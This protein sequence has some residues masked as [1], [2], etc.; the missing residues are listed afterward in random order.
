M[1]INAPLEL[2]SKLSRFGKSDITGTG[3]INNISLS[4]DVV[5]FT[6]NTP[7]LTGIDNPTGS[8][9][10]VIILYKGN[11]N[12]TLKHLDVN[13]SP[14]NQIITLDGNDFTIQP[15]N[16]IVL[17][18]DITDLKWRISYSSKNLTSQFVSS[19]D[20]SRWNN[21]VSN[22]GNVS[23]NINISFSTNRV[24]LL[25]LT[26][27]LTVSLLGGVAGDVYVIRAMQDVPGN[28]T[29]TFADAGLSVIVKS[30]NT[31]D[32]GG[33][34]KTIITLFYDGTQYLVTMVS[35]F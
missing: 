6:G 8:M 32:L 28:R 9:F 23:G 13:S 16:K 12:L 14:N 29:F 31:I 4:T 27:N 34:K 1:K 3:N 2:K 21:T 24:I 22:L 7:I 10:E 15:G 18:Y 19:S 35:G 11:G 30:G 17:T 5:Y 25:T 33:S 26:G 20:I